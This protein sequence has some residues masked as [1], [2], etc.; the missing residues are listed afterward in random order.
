MNLHENLHSHDIRA[1][2]RQEIF[3]P[4]SCTKLSVCQQK[5]LHPVDRKIHTSYFQMKQILKD[6][7]YI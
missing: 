1:I 7:V 4:H 6:T 3:Q 5:C 2:S